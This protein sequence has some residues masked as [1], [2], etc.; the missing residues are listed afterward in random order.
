VARPRST[1]ASA[2][3]GSRPPTASTT[4]DDSDRVSIPRSYA[5]TSPATPPG[6]STGRQRP[7]GA[8]PTS[9]STRSK[10]ITQPSYSSIAG[11]PCIGGQQARR[12]SSTLG[13]S[14]WRSV[15]ARGS[16]MTR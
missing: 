8:I 10:P 1:S 6:R 14:R 2:A 12:L 4:P 11:R 13:T 3:T 5:S 9:A 7:A 16:P 15:L